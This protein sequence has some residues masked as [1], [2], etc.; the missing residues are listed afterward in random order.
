MLIIV[1]NIPDALLSHFTVAT[2]I[3]PLF[4][5][6]FSILTLHTFTFYSPYILHTH[7]SLTALSHF[8]HYCPWRPFYRYPSISTQFPL[9]TRSSLTLYGHHLVKEK[10]ERKGINGTAFKNCYLNKLHVLEIAWSG[11]GRAIKRVEN[12]KIPREWQQIIYTVNV[13]SAGNKRHVVFQL[14]PVQEIHV[15]IFL[16]YC[17]LGERLSPSHQV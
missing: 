7:T 11:R 10:K 2:R 4:A 3:P 17:Y 8:P 15:Y 12:E 5:L 9:I 6:S 1:G 16:W 14:S 13:T